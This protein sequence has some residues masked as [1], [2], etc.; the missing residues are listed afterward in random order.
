MATNAQMAALLRSIADGLLEPVATVTGLPAPVVQA[1]V[2]GSTTGAVKAGK[3]KGRKGKVSAYNKAF[4]KAFK[5]QKAK[6]TK[7]NGDFKKG[8]NSSKCMSAAHKET[9]RM[10]KR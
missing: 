10:M 3:A 4:A 5:R 1:F 2:E 9:K 6:M 7:K 8:C